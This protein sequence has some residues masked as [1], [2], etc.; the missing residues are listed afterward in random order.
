[1]NRTTPFKNWN[2]VPVLFGLHTASIVFDTAEETLKRLAAKGEVPA[3]KMGGKWMFEKTRVMEYFGI[4]STDDSDRIRDL[5]KEVDYL[6]R[7][8]CESI[9]RRDAI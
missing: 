4:K 1:M 2:T 8:I 9:E 7:I 6:R 5:E 3:K